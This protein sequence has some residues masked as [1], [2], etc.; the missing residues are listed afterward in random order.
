MTVRPTLILWYFLA[1]EERDMDNGIGAG[2]PLDETDFANGDAI[3]TS[4]PG[5]NED[6]E[7]AIEH[8]DGFEGDII[9]NAEQAAII[10]NGTEEDL[11]SASTDDRHRWPKS[12][13]NI[14][15]PYVLSSSYSKK[16]RARIARAFTEYELKTCIR[17]INR[18]LLQLG[19][20]HIP[21]SLKICPI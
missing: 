17:Y 8:E 20:Y 15:V 2:T 6:L 7:Y 3:D 1:L 19:S 12:G 14:L 4:M 21:V 5:E 10:A 16:E 11:R 18:K 13:S 9:L